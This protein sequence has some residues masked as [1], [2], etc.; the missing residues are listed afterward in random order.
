M[1]GIS[2]QEIG[3]PENKYRYNG[4]E[5]Q[6]QEFNDGSGLEWYDYGARM[7]D[8]QIG[9]WDRIDPLAGQSRQWSPYNYAYNNPLRFIDPDGMTGYDWIKFKTDDD[10]TRVKW[11]ED[12]HNQEQAEEKYGKE[13][14][15]IGKSGTWNSNQYGDQTWQLNSDGTFAEVKY[16]PAAFIPTISPE[17]VDKIGFGLTLGPAPSEEQLYGLTQLFWYGEGLRGESLGNKYD[18]KR[19]FYFLDD[20]AMA[21]LK[22]PGSYLST[23][24][25]PEMPDAELPND[26]AEKANTKSESDGKHAPNTTYFDGDGINVWDMR[27]DEKGN[28]KDTIKYNK[29]T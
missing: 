10:I 2:Y 23:K 6:H 3:K 1:A 9:R 26:L 16:S 17:A 29:I 4:K 7:Y 13:A 27:T 25:R 28:V 22:L 14:K 5:L 21:A 12:V 24:E 20:D 19:P 15:D 18:P 8:V 11:D